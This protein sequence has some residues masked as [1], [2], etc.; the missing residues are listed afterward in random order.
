VIDFSFLTEPLAENQPCGPDLDIEGDPEYFN[1]LIPAE[2]RLPNA[3]FD[4][5]GRDIKGDLVFDRSAIDLESEVKQITAL[6]GKSRDLRLLALLAQFHSVTANLDGFASCLK[7]IRDLLEARWQDV[8]PASADSDLSLRMVSVEAIDDRVRVAIPISF[9]PLL[10]DKKIGIITYRS[11]EIAI[12]PESKRANETPLPHSDVQEALRSESGR[13]ALVQTISVVRNCIEC[14]VSIRNIF[15]QKTDFQYVPSFENTL[16]VLEDISK[17]VIDEVPD[18]LGAAAGE[19]N[20]G[21]IAAAQGQIQED[22]APLNS[23]DGISA[24]KSAVGP[25][26]TLSNHGEAKALLREIEGYFSAREPSSPALMLVRQARMLVGRPLV[27]ALE[28]IA[29]SRLDS[30]RIVFDTTS[31]FSIGIERMR[32]LSASTVESTGHEP[33]PSGATAPAEAIT[34]RPM[35]VTAMLSVESFLSAI[36]PS[37][38]TPLLLSKA[39][40]LMSKNFADLLKEI[41]GSGNAQAG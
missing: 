10:R 31:G 27:E 13:Q 35:A 40:A 24:G 20:G 21:N 7:A 2:G 29:P 18:L 30:A 28:A 12:R 16:G 22:G 39:R 19:A 32:D 1:Y 5:S 17:A 41:L 4:M 25:L 36:E 26:L 37:S 23:P 38:P 6:L 8:H 9:F 33:S 34:T 14:L 3:Y 15:R 11:L